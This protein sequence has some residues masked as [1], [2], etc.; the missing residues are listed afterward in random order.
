M[1]S[2]C[3]NSPPYNARG[4][5]GVPSNPERAL[6][7]FRRKSD[8][9]TTLPEHMPS[10]H[11]RYAGWTIDRIRREAAAIGPDTARLTTVILETRSHPEQ[12]FRAGLGILRLARQY[13]TSRLEAACRRG[14]DLGARSYGSIS[15]ILQHGLDRRP[16]PPAA[17]SFVAKALL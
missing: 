10:A 11:R 2:T 17:R 16:R 13:G 12:G 1:L 6:C 5:F 7:R 9:D 8:S 15:S 3:T 14:L 4:P